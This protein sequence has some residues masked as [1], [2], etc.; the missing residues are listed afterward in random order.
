MRIII[1]FFLFLWHQVYADTMDHYMSIADNIPKMEMKA[2][3]QSQAWARSARNV[4]IITCESIAETI[5]QANVYAQKQDNPFFCL[6]ANK[7]LT[8]SVL[9]ELIQQTYKEI[10]ELQKDRMTVSE[11]AWIAVKKNF[12]CKQRSTHAKQMEH[13]S[14]LFSH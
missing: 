8:A 12:P 5:N 6:P 2:D 9:N 11:V 4:L 3:S 14:A 13:V 7:Q 10:P 1:A